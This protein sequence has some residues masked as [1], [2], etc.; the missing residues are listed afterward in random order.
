MEDAMK[1]CSLQP[2][3][4]A[5]LIQVEGVALPDWILDMWEG[6]KKFQ[7]YP[8]DLLIATYPKAG[9]TWIQEIVDMILNEGDL[10]KCQRAP[11]HERI[12]FLE[13]NEMPP[14]PS[15]LDMIAAMTPPRVIKTH[16]PFQLVPQSFWEQDCKAI[17]VARNAKDNLVSFFFFDKMCRDQPD[18]GTWDEYFWKFLS[19]Q[20]SWGSWYDHVKGWWKHK[21]K[22]RIL[23]LFYEDMK[24]DPKREIKKVIHFLEKDLPDEVVNK[25]V[26]HT[27]FEIMKNNPMANYSFVP[28]QVFNQSV[29]QFMRKGA[30]GDWKNHLTVAQ[31]EIFDADY[32]DKM[33]DMTLSFRNEL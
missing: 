16:L 25:I 30:V 27:S 18:P 5:K 4:R 24:E 15:G 33:A 12:P 7:A 31:N 29:S 21:D 6:V 3:K 14:Y 9:T 2:V 17:Y 11:T 20:I 1:E 28:D 13:C 19:G 32:R 10:E 26:Y 22:Q 8:D 23:Y